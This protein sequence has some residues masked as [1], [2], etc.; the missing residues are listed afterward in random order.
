MADSKELVE[1]RITLTS[2]IPSGSWTLYFHSQDENKW[3]LNTFV[4]LGPLKTWFQF[5]AV[6]NT[7]KMESL[8]DGMFFMMRDPSPPLWESHHHIR[9]GCYSFRC[10]RYNAAD[11]YINYIIAAMMDVLTDESNTINGI[12]I[13]NKRGFNVIKV[14]NTDASKCSHPTDL[15]SIHKSVSHGDIIYTPFV[16]KRM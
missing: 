9:G 2:S 10:Q 8:S 7:L 15:K 11:I 5:W 12:T 4:S 3:T 14:W 16:Q 13:S 1:S 6:I